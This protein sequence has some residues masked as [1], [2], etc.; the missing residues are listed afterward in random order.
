MEALQQL[1]KIVNRK[2]LSKID[3][4][5]K[6]FLNNTNSNIYQLLYEGLENGKITD[7]A[8]AAAYVYGS[9]EK[10][11]KFRKL[12]QRFKNKLQ[13]TV[14]LLDADDVFQS[15]KSRVYY[16]CVL[17][18]HIIEIIIQLNGTTKLVYELVKENYSKA[19]QYN[20]YSIL[21]NYSYY[22]LSYYAINGE[23]KLFDKEQQLFLL[24]VDLAQKEQL[25]K[26]LY[27]K[28]I[29]LFEELTP[30]T[31]EL[32]NTVNKNL[33]ELLKIKEE[34]KNIEVNFYYYFLALDFYQKS[35]QLDELIRIC[36]EADQLMDNNHAAYTNTRKTIVFLSRLYSILTT[37]KYNEGIN[38]IQSSEQIKIP[39]GNVNWFILKEIEFKLFLQIDRLQEAYSVY[40]EVKK[41][42]NFE[43]QT[44]KTKERWLIYH[45]YCVFMDNYI[46]QGDYKYSLGRLLNEVQVNVKDKSGFNYALR[47][48]EIL[49]NAARNDFNLIFSKID[50]LRVYRSRYLNDNT[51]K[52]NHLFLSLLIKAEKS[53]YNAKTMKEAK[54]PEIAELRKQNL[55]IIADWEIMPYERLW[56]IFVELSEKNKIK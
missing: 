23:K 48:I 55:Y 29:I 53:G 56:D 32:L 39:I 30:I 44:Q 19:K 37:R 24:Y 47:I 33:D 14:L 51:Y 8:S 52:R 26:F 42:K 38:F 49:F 18:N 21:K 34:L 45:A 50:A 43:R 36:N 54:W 46:N 7:D 27:F 10:D 12:K 25:A 20:F 17:T 3:V 1:V 13:K 6:T 31:D 2:R 41:N 4:F 5:D 11:A 40:E 9:E 15:E 28:S 22:L 35:N 16:E